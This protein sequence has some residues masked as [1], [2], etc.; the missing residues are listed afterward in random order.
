[1]WDRWK[2]TILF[3]GLV[4]VSLAVYWV[5]DVQNDRRVMLACDSV[6]QVKDAALTLA[7]PVSPKGVTDSATL[8]RIRIANAQ[9]AEVRAQLARDLACR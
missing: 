6:T 1:L 3:C 2:I 8:E 4:L 7:R 9:R 5:N